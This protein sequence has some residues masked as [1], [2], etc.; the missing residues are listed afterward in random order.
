MKKWICLVLALVLTAMLFTGCG[1]KKKLLGVWSCTVDL[2]GEAQKI[3]EE[4]GLGGAFTVT[5]FAVTATLEFGKD[6]LFRLRLDPE[7][8]D[9]RLDVLLADLEEGLLELLQVQLGEKVDISLEEILTMSGQNKEALTQQLRQQ[10]PVEDFRQRLE[11]ITA[12]SG[13]YKVKKE[14]LLL[15]ADADSLEEDWGISY[16]VEDGV[17]QLALPEVPGTFTA[18]NRILEQLPLEFTKK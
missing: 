15:G 7:D 9:A 11:E 17:L 6:D 10:F 18:G 4:S 1:A 5:D 8:L 2:S 16:V 12:L 3:L 14:Q 13:S